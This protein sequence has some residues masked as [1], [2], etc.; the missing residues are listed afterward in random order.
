MPEEKEYQ[1][2]FDELLDYERYGIPI[3]MNGT[4]ASPMQVVSA[5][6]VK[7]ENNTYM[8]D[9]V[10]DDMGHVKELCFYSIKKNDK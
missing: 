5:H 8:R 3:K 10:T 1:E 2:M 6:M 7:E 4:Y 9:Y